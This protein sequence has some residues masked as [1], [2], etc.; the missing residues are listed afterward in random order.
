MPKENREGIR[1]RKDGQ[2]CG[3][4]TTGAN[5][6]VFLSAAVLIAVQFPKLNSAT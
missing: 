3:T 1:I 5:D 6:F 4:A 2:T